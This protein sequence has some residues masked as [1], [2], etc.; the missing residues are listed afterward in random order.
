MGL[1]PF[2]SPSRPRAVCPAEVARGVVAG[3]ILARIPQWLVIHDVVPHAARLLLARLG[4]CLR[5]T[6]PWRT[7]R[8]GSAFAFPFAAYAPSGSSVGLGVVAHAGGGR[9]VPDGAVALGLGVGIARGLPLRGRGAGVAGAVRVLGGAGVGRAVLL[10]GPGLHMTVLNAL[11]FYNGLLHAFLYQLTWLS[12][13]IGCSCTSLASSWLCGRRS[14]SRLRG[15]VGRLRAR[16]WGPPRCGPLLDPRPPHGAVRG[17]G[18][19]A[20]PLHW[21]VL[22]LRRPYLTV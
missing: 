3:R 9:R 13:R 10:S 17:V 7:G 12:A 18:V 11:P 6:A 14:G 15:R 1:W 4:R 19:D 21:R 5:I 8:R 22:A 16:L 20:V 2:P